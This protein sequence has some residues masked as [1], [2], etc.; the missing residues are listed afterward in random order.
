MTAVQTYEV[1]A[2][3]TQYRVVFTHCV[4]IDIDDCT[5]SVWVII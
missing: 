5:S 3:V 4:M 1:A 2:L